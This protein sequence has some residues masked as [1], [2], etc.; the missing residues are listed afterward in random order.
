MFQ[1]GNSRSVERTFR[2]IAKASNGA[3]AGSI[4]APHVSSARSY[5]QSQSSLSVARKRLP[6][7]ATPAPSSCSVSCDEHH[8][9]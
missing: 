4:Q 1:E 7:A 5:A 8:S 2:A 6:R 3:I 9:P